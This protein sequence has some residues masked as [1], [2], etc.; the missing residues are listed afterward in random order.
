MSQHQFRFF[1]DVGD[2]LVMSASQTLHGRTAFID[3]TASSNAALK[4]QPSLQQPNHSP[5]PSVVGSRFLT[6]CWIS[7]PSTPITPILS[8]PIHRS[9]SSSSSSSI[10]M[11]SL[12]RS[13]LQQ[14]FQMRSVLHL[15]TIDF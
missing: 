7:F 14:D 11:R 5:I 13:S 9:M 4:S 2:H 8:A 10:R 15:P 3:H 1:L 12:M 6:R